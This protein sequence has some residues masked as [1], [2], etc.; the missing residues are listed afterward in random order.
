MVHDLAG[1]ARGSMAVRFGRLDLATPA[2]CMRPSSRSR[3]AITVLRFDHALRLR[4]GVKRW[5]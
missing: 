2:V 1:D 5:Q 4:R 3:S